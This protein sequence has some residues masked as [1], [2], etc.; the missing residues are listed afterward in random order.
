MVGGPGRL[1]HKDF[2]CQ[3]DYPHFH[4]E[5]QRA[6]DRLGQRSGLP[7]SWV[8]GEHP[9]A[10][11]PWIV[12]SREKGKAEEGGLCRFPAGQRGDVSGSCSGGWCARCVRGGIPRWG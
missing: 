11:G 8:F 10:V 6:V 7:H 12:G 4:E 1:A 2:M 9:L 5:T 3:A